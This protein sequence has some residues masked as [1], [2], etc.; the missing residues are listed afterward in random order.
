M[1]SV[2]ECRLQVAAERW[3]EWVHRCW[4][5]K[6][7]PAGD[8][9]VRAMRTT[10]L[11]AHLP[12]LRRPQLRPHLLHRPNPSTEPAPRRAV[13]AGAAAAAVPGPYLSLVQTFSPVL[14]AVGYT[15]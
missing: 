9:V 10:R 4:T 13:S 12:Q 5:V 6:A 11:V 3:W 2:T 15:A 1:S 14:L 8:S 7:V